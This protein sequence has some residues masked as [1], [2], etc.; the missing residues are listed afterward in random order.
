MLGIYD[1]EEDTF[2][3]HDALRSDPLRENDND[4]DNILH[5]KMLCQFLSSKRPIYLV[6]AFPGT[7]THLTLT[8]LIFISR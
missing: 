1:S 4:S 3:I 2:T 7:D 5:E 8:L 6:S